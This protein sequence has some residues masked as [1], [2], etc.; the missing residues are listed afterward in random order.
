MAPGSFS[1]LQVRRG[2]PGREGDQAIEARI[3]MGTDRSL[4]SFANASPL[5]LS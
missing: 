1:S 5:T 2:G 4:D 3:V